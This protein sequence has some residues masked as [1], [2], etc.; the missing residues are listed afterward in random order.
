MDASLSSKK[1]SFSSRST[2]RSTCAKSNRAARRSSTALGPGHAPEATIV[3]VTTSLSEARRRSVMRCDSSISART[4]SHDVSIT[5]SDSRYS[6]DVAQPELTSLLRRARPRT[7]GTTRSSIALGPGRSVSTSASSPS[8]AAS[9]WGRRAG[10]CTSIL[11]TSTVISPTACCTMSRPSCSP[12]ALALALSSSRD[13]PR[14]RSLIDSS[15][16]TAGPDDLGSI[17]TPSRRSPRPGQTSTARSRAS[18]TPAG[19]ASSRSILVRSISSLAE[20]THA[21]LM[22]LG[23]HLPVASLAFCA[24]VAARPATSWSIC[25]LCLRKWSHSGG[26]GSSAGGSCADACRY[27]SSRPVAMSVSAAA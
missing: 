2:W 1:S 18:S 14:T 21:S 16:C 23:G 11:A 15:I 5:R 27:A 26:A 8:A 13:R 7:T 6:S 25:A 9:S 4:S 10:A 19:R 3:L 20:A 22:S 17:A 24:K 12:A